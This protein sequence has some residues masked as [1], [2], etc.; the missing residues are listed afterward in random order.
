[1]IKIMITVRNRLAITTKCITALKNHTSSPHQ[2]YIYENLTDYKIYEHFMYWAMLYEKGLIS[3]V[4]F[5]T[6]DSTFNS[7]SKTV[8]SNLFGLQHEEDLEKDKYDFLVLMDNDMIVTPDWDLKVRKAW[9]DINKFNLKNIKIISQLPGGIKERKKLAEKIGDYEAEIGKLG[10]SGF[11][12]IKPDFFRT[13]GFL[14][15]KSTYGI[16]K[17]HDQE[18]W[19]I[20]NSHTKG[21]PYILGLRTKLAYH[22]GYYVGSVCNVLTKV[23]DDKIAKQKIKFDSAEEEINKMSFVEFYSMVEKKKD[24]IKDY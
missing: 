23:K 5:S 18:Y 19:K 9:K 13:V 17:K 22:C 8:S 12:C 21:E 2:I 10:G 20:L 11:W 7:F 3:Q 16:N 4:T 6:K 1:M 24:L 15:V 14:K